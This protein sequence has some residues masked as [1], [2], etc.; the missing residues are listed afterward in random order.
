M[1][2]HAVSMAFKN[3][4]PHR[5]KSGYT[6]IIC[7]IA[8]DRTSVFDMFDPEPALVIWIEGGD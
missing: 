1:V 2:N 5:R 7:A 3:P 6:P 4:V 8:C